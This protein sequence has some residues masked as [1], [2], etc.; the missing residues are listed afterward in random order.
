MRSFKSRF[1]SEN[2]K[3]KAGEQS[4]VN[5]VEYFWHRDEV[6]YCSK[7]EL[8]VDDWAYVSMLDAIGGAKENIFMES[9]IFNDDKAGKIFSD[10]LIFAAKRGVDIYL[11]IDGL[12]TMNVRGTFFEK[13]KHAGINLHVY[14]PVAPFKKG[15]NL[16]KRNHRKLLVVDGCIAFAGGHNIGDEWLAKEWGGKGW[17]DIHCRI[18]GDAVKNV[19]FIMMRLWEKKKGTRFNLKTGCNS[20]DKCQIPVK[21]ITS[22]NIRS[23]RGIRKSY[24]YAI[25]KATSYIY[26]ANA[27]F[28]PGLL[29]RRALIKAVKR[30]VDVKIMVPAH[31]DVWPVHMAGAATYGRLLD[32]GVRIFEWKNT[33]LHA[34][35][36]VIDDVWATV[37]SYNLDNRSYKLNLEVNFNIADKAFCEKLR[38]VFTTDLSNCGEIDFVA[39]KNRPLILK[40]T[41]RFFYLF[42]K[43]M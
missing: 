6:L 31:G 3:I 36:A 35:S 22:K 1:F 28:I 7:V 38:T 32:K 29:V 4:S 16:F 2:N 27:Y 37:G 40:I 33:V 20:S 42:R 21:V 13:L 39:W 18:E 11:I 25:K 14:H 26:I 41:E 8:L 30:G 12:G 19:L 24:L 9:Y 23:I 17:H 5:P 10:A 15:F 43:L 34:K